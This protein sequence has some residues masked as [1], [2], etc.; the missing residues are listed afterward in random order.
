MGPARLCIDDGKELAPRAHRLRVLLGHRIDDLTEVVEI[1][2]HPRGEELPERHFP[3]GGMEAPS[4][5]ASDSITLVR[6]IQS[7]SSTW[8]RCPTTWKGDHVSGPSS[9]AIQ[10]SDRSES[11]A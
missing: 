4:L 9:P 3:K 11:I 10:S 5:Q 7:H 1:V 8:M 2:P 6:S